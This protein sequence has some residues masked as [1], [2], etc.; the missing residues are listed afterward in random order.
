ML[1]ATRQ[2]STLFFF[3]LASHKEKIP[4]NIEKK[5]PNIWNKGVCVADGSEKCCE[6]QPCVL[7]WIS[8]EGSTEMKKGDAMAAGKKKDQ[9][10]ETRDNQGTDRRVV[11]CLLVNAGRVPL[12]WSGSPA[13]AS[14]WPAFGLPPRRHAVVNNG[15][16]QRGR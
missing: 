9:V 13:A 2:L 16:I 7:V 1:L 14:P 4:L 12:Q 5:S 15:G 10:Q 6:F 8:Q 3:F 11:R